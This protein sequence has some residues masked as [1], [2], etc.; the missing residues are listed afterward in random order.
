MEYLNNFKPDTITLEDV[1]SYK[2]LKSYIE[3]ST[4]IFNKSREKSTDSYTVFDSDKIVLDAPEVYIEV[5]DYKDDIIREK[6]K[7]DGL[8]GLTNMNFTAGEMFYNILMLENKVNG[9]TSQFEKIEFIDY[10]N[11]IP[12]YRAHFY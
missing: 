1:D 4:L 11:N 6:F 2:K 10:L 5:L 7:A 9:D 8:P 12:I 3:I